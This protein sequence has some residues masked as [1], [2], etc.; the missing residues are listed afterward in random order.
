[1]NINHKNSQGSHSNKR[2]DFQDFLALKIPE[3]RDILYHHFAPSGS[4]FDSKTRRSYCHL[5]YFCQFPTWSITAS[6]TTLHCTGY[7]SFSDIT[8]KKTNIINNFFQHYTTQ[9][10]GLSREFFSSNAQFQNFSGPEKSE[11]EFQDPWQVAC[12]SVQTDSRNKS[13]TE[14]H[15][16]LAAVQRHSIGGGISPV[17]RAH[18]S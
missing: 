6:I 8:Q 18:I 15:D 2:S 10:A 12:H 3:N 11:H 13:S 16:T 5:K 1:M 9:N 17:C 14:I 7:S 4:F